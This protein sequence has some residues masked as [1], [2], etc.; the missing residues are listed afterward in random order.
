MGKTGDVSAFQGWVIEVIEIV[1][2]GDRVAAFEQRLGDVRADES[3]PAG[4]QHLHAGEGY[5]RR[6]A[7]SSH[8]LSTISVHKAR[9]WSAL[10]RQCSSNNAV[11]ARG[12]TPS[13]ASRS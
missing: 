1:H 9:A 8:S 6:A 10:R 3:G 13:L 7:Q 2:H 12:W 11:A 5:Q 4:D